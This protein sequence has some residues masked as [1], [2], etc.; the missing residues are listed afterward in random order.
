MRRLLLAA[1]GAMV[2][3]AAPAAER[4]PSRAVDVLKPVAALPSHALARMPGAIAVARMP[5]GDYL[6]LDRREHALFRVD[7]AGDRVR[8]LVEVGIEGGRLLRPSAMSLAANGIVAVLDA[9]TAYQRVQYFDTDG[10]LIGIFYLPLSASPHVIAGEQVIAGAGAMAFTGRTFLVNEPSWGSLFAELDNSGAVIRHVGE[11]RRTGF[12]SDKVLHTAFNTGL[13][14]VDPT[15]GA[16]FV[17]QTGVPMFRK[18]AA[19]GRLVFERHIEG[20]ELDPIIQTLPTRWIPRNDGSR[21]FPIPVIHTAAADA[22]GRLWVAV[23]SGY[24]Y[25]YD[26]N[27]DKIRTVRFDGARTISPTSFQFPRPG[28]LVLGPEGYEFDVGP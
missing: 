28:R 3:A 2:L 4:T 19:D 20:V 22:Q 25:V 21:P 6:V 10:K 14:V 8:R 12:E 16:Y 27:G 26:P 24:T 9:P 23:R 11:L 7:S 1:A 5:S 18:Y 13:P 15:G 17:F